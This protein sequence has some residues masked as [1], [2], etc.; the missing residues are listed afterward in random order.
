MPDTNDIEE[1]KQ[2]INSSGNMTSSRGRTADIKELPVSQMQ[3]GLE[4]DHIVSQ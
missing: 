3:L 2:V 4:P 1:K